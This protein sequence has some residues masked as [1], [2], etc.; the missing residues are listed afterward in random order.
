M[1]IPGRGIEVKIENKTV[2]LG[3]KQLMDEKNIYINLQKK[4]MILLIQV[5]HQ[6]L[7]LLKENLLE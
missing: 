4:Q 5:K 2:L 1:A 3:N 6:C 7:W